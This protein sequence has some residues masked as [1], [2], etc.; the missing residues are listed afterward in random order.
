MK[1]N[2]H[3]LGRGASENNIHPNL[4]SKWKRTVISDESI[5]KRQIQ[6]VHDL[7]CK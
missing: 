1:R 5:K 2:R 3:C 6:K 4:L 7:L